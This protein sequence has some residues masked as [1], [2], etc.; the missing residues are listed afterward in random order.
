MATTMTGVR[1]RLRGTDF[2]AAGAASWI[3]WNRLL[4]VGAA[5]DVAAHTMPTPANAHR[6]RVIFLFMLV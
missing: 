5:D 1:S 2:A 6:S 4:L 3:R